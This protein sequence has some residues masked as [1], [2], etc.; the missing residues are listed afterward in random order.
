L[1]PVITNNYF[2]DQKDAHLSQNIRLLDQRKSVESLSK[3]IQ[4]QSGIK[5]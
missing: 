2:K 4:E 5:P 3:F 1:N